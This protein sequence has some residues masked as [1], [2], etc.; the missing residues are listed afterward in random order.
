M[1]IGFPRR[2]AR[3]S[4]G[5]IAGDARRA[6]TSSVTPSLLAFPV[7]TTRAH[8]LSGILSRCHHLDIS[9][10][11][12]PGPRSA[13]IASRDVQSSMMERNESTIPNQI[14]RTVF[15]NKHN[16]SGDGVC[17]QGHSVFMKKTRNI[18]S[19]KEQFLARVAFARHRAGFTQASIAIEMGLADE[20]DTNAASSY[21][22]YETRSFMPHD[23]I[24]QFCALTEITTGWLFSGPAVA[25]PIEKRG[26][27][28]KPPPTRRSAAH[29]HE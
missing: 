11:S 14:R 16:L 29:Q 9:P 27:K 20:D 8:H 25:R 10:A 13:A 2:H 17:S 7:S 1:V 18:S 23:L 28:P 26:R 3:A 22:K 19:F 24:N 4:S 6:K 21:Q 15:K 12:A 5:E